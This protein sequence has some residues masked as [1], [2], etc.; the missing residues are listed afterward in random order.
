[1]VGAII[2]AAALNVSFGLSYVPSY[3]KYTAQITAGALIGCS[4]GKNDVKRLKLLV[5][6]LLALLGGLL[7][8]NILL[9]FFIYYISPMDLL[10]SLMSC[11]PG[12]MTDIPLISA[13]MGADSPKVAVLQFVRMATGISL[14]PSLISIITDKKNKKDT[15]SEQDKPLEEE[16]IEDF[17]EHTLSRF[18]QTI[19]IAAVFGILGAVLHIPSGA[20]LFSMV[21]TLCFKLFSNKSYMPNW[22]K[23]LAQVLSGAY[24]GSSMTYNDVLEIKHLIIPALVLV[25]CYFATSFILGKVLSRHFGMSLKEAM[26]AATPAGATDMA[27]ILSDIGVQST[28]LI[29]LQIIRMLIVIGVFPPII[30]LIVLLAG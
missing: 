9:G 20:L 12:G 16:K 17:H 29:V 14:F 6:P 26:L 28:D 25:A 24:V 23:R 19:S 27:L 3:A 15:A 13:D 21:A 11:I 1:M 8:L 7:L 2:G 10:T 5:K 22:A 4:M 18:L 30:N